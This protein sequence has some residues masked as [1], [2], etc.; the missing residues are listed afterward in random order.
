MHAGPAED[1]ELGTDPS[2]IVAAPPI[3]SLTP[4]AGASGA[5]RSAGRRRKGVPDIKPRKFKSLRSR[6]GSRKIQEPSESP[7][8]TLLG[9]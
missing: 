4:T 5:D 8:S 2:D 1:P 6:N 9:R 3:R 7:P